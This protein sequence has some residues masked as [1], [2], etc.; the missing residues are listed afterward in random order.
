VKVAP[1][2]F[3]RWNTRTDFGLDLAALYKQSNWPSGLNTAKSGSDFITG[4]FVDMRVRLNPK[5]EMI[6]SFGMVYKDAS[7]YWRLGL[8]YRL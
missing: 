8:A 2:F 5:L 4:A 7:I 3:Y 1:R 6:Q